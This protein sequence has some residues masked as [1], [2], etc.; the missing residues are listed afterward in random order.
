VKE[1]VLEILGSA[2]EPLK[3][4]EVIERVRRIVPRRGFG[5]KDRR[6]RRF[7]MVLDLA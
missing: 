5:C 3:R 7:G 2:R 6:R 4:S 1:I